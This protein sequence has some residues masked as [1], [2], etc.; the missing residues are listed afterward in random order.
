MLVVTAANC[1]KEPIHTPGSIQPFGV[2]IA[3]EP[4]SGF[5]ITQVSAN[6]FPAIRKNSTE[7]I[8]TNLRELFL[9]PEL[10]LKNVSSLIEA[11]DRRAM[12]RHFPVDLKGASPSRYEATLHDSGNELILELESLSFGGAERIDHAEVQD[13]IERCF[14]ALRTSIDLTDLCENAAQQVRDFTGFDRVMIYRFDEQWNGQVIAEDHAD[15]VFPYLGHR[16]P[17]S[18]IPK[19]ARDTFLKNWLRMIPDARYVPIL[20]E[21]A[22]DTAPKPPLNLLRSVLRSVSPVHLEYLANMGVRA[23]LTISLIDRDRLWGLIACHH[24][25]PKYLPRWARSGLVLLGQMM[26]SL[27]SYKEQTQDSEYRQQLENVHY[28]LLEYMS[29]EE[30]LVAGLIRYSPNLLDLTSAQAAAAAICV[31]GQWSLIGQVPDLNEIDRLADWLGDHMPAFGIF[32]TDSL[33]AM[34]PRAANFKDVASGLLAISIPKSQKNYILWFRPEV[35]Q[36]VTWAGEPEKDVEF[37]RGELRLH[38]RKSFEAW[39]E[40]VRLTS[41][42]W[43]KV[44]IEAAMELRRSIIE[45]DLERQFLRAQES[46]RA[47]ADILAVVSHDLRNPLT[48]VKMNAGLIR[49]LLQSGLGPETGDRV[50]AQIGRIENSSRRMERL[51]Q[52]L[53]DISKIEA[54]GLPTE[55]KLGDASD[56]LREAIDLLEPLATLKSIRLLEQN[57]C[58]GDACHSLFDRE[59]LLQVLS[60]LIGNAIKFSPEGSTITIRVKPLVREVLFEVEDEGP[61]IAKENLEQVFSRFWQGDALN[62]R[63]TGLG[64]AIA[65]GIIETHGGRIWAESELGRGSIFRFTVPS[66]SQPTLGPDARTGK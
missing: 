13:R 48:S 30:S 45:L 54:G 61:G 53:L 4:T 57:G 5:R 3:F 27:L 46:D 32:H 31:E 17:A 34:Y 12:V 66:V 24:R 20:I 22:R 11:P 49:R 65:K 58:S 25:S 26:P 52:D 60:N 15:D 9:D 64:L 14:E 42:P 59:R 37:V 29:K 35:I 6:L 62:K 19:Q 38:P 56:L 21:S 10:L 41:V 16:F 1:E 55:K 43:R 33:P 2:L 8:G 36:T 51:I 7:L 18:D 63:G 50:E 47:K 40:N 44:E 23:T 39:K 28:S